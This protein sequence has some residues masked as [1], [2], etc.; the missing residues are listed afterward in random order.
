[1]NIGDMF[2][3]EEEQRINDELERCKNDNITKYAHDVNERVT[4][5]SSMI[6]IINRDLKRIMVDQTIVNQKRLT[7]KILDYIGYL[8]SKIDKGSGN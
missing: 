5:A 3:K 2:S 4:H 8:E 1:M 6:E 7:I